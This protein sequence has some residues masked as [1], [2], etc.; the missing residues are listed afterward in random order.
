MFDITVV[1]HG[2]SLGVLYRGHS[3]LGTRHSLGSVGWA[4]LGGWQGIAGEGPQKN[5]KT[6]SDQFKQVRGSYIDA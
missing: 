1:L 6:Y 3:G 5:K 4:S 2:P